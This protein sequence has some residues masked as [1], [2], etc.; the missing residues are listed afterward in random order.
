MLYTTSP[1]H[2]FPILYM[3]G[4]RPVQNQHG[5]CN[6]FGWYDVF[7]VLSNV[8]EEKSTDCALTQVNPIQLMASASMSPSIEG[9]EVRLG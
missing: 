4:W 8:A 6:L 2:S 7:V 9:H 5:Q 3:L 1:S